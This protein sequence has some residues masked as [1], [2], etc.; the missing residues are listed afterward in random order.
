MFEMKLIREIP[1]HYDMLLELYEPELFFRDNI[2]VDLPMPDLNA[3]SS[4][5]S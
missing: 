1:S 3:I 4:A 2:R 5:I